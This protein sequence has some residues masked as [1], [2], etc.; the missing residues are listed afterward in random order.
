MKKLIIIYALILMV[1]SL[2]LK[3]DESEFD[4]DLARHG[5]K[6]VG[7]VK[8][9]IGSGLDYGE[10]TNKFLSLGVGLFSSEHL[11]GLSNFFHTGF[12]YKKIYSLIFS[13]RHI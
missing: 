1:T 7:C 11:K 9:W 10:I 2:P 13:F 6:Y 12:A 5:A 4:Q 3:K 8:E